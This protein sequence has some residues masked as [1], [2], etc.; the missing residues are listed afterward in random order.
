MQTTSLSGWV[1]T[2]H[3]EFQ[4]GKEQQCH[5]DRRR[6]GYAVA[7][8]STRARAAASLIRSAVA[9]GWET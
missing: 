6:A 7:G 5:A 3:L 2:S 8:G 4:S 9:R 1:D